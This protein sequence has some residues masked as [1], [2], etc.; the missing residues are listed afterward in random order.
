MRLHVRVTNLRGKGES[1]AGHV[2]FDVTNSMTE[3]EPVMNK[4]VWAQKGGGPCGLAF[5]QCEG[6]V[7]SSRTRNLFRTMIQDFQ[8]DFL[9]YESTTLIKGAEMHQ[10]GDDDV[11]AAVEEVEYSDTESEESTPRNMKRGST[12]G[13]D[14]SG[15]ST[16]K[17]PGTARATTQASAASTN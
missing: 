15:I 7:R 14:R 3:E 8:T 9:H 12:R 17:T 13:T 16:P 5:T 11:S 6:V 10:N 4:V 2:H 1:Y